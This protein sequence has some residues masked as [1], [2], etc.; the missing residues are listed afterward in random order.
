MN[1]DFF[2][3]PYS[4][5]SLEPTISSETISFHYEK[6]HKAYYDNLVRLLGE[7]SIEEESLEDII[8]KAHKDESLRLLYNNASQVFNHDFFWESL[9]PEKIE[10]SDYLVSLIEDNFSS[11]DKFL[12]ELKSKALNHFASGWVWLVLDSN[13]GL[14]IITTSNADSP[15]ILGFK[16]LLTIDVW[17]HSYYIDYRN[18]RALY[19]DSVIGSLINWNFVES[20]IKRHI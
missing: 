13:G 17:E 8:L 12:D 11:W 10:P 2:K 6:H 1:L 20:N 3:L 14:K 5:N 4:N 16:P 7:S 19:L 15:I 18:A 9:S